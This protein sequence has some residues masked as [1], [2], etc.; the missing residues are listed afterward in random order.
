MR[1]IRWLRASAGVM[2][3][4]GGLAVS[5]VAFTASSG[6]ST[7]AKKSFAAQTFT[8]KLSGVCPNPLVVQTNWLPESDHGALYE[9]IGAGGTMKQYSY[10]GPLGST[11]IQLE[12]LSG[13]PGDS[14]QPTA[15]TLY[16]GNPVVG[17][18]PNLSEDSTETTIQLS[19]KFPTIGVAAMQDH[20]PQILI[21][22]PSKFSNLSTVKSL[23]TAANKGAHFYVTSLTSVYVQYLISAG[24]PESAFIGGYAGDL[25]KFVTGGGLMV[26]QGYADSEPY[27]LA[28]DTPAW[29][30]K[31]IKY[32]YVYKLGLNDYPSAIQVATSKLKSMTPCLKRLVPMM[33][34]AQV[35]YA[36]DPTTVNKVL[37]QFNPNFS[38]SY[39][40]TPVAESLWAIKVQK[41][42]KIVG[43]SLGGKGAAGGF[44]FQ[45]ISQTVKLLLP[46]FQKESPGT[47]N[48]GA[49]AS[50]LVTNR[51]IDTS[52]KYPS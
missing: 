17:V 19:K 27:Q 9:L 13:G 43:N 11:G 41:S 40:T 16:S 44:D 3:M 45:R 26:N 7:T 50:S 2:T 23:I 31:P 32:T 10:M 51:F 28:H 5:T 38:A 25:A 52:I 37:A 6:A 39:W 47:F 46:I 24:V 20:D 48:T 15:A 42:Q 36:K 21:Y 33:Q 12:I 8:A 30:G 35:A 4:A 14:Y 49:T 34:T 22:D 1:A 18:T 29:G